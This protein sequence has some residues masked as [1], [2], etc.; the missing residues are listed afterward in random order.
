VSKFHPEQRQGL[1]DLSSKIKS[2]NETLKIE[3]SRL[4]NVNRKIGKLENLFSDTSSL[5]MSPYM[6]DK[7]NNAT[8]KKYEPFLIEL[9]SEIKEMR[10]IATKQIND[11][12]IVMSD[13][14]K[15]RYDFVMKYGEYADDLKVEK[16]KGF[17]KKEKLAKKREKINK[18][19]KIVKEYF[20]LFFTEYY[21]INNLIDELY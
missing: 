12:K 2:L 4:L 10:T 14:T 7:P 13:G 8:Y 15:M 21:S 20:D 16:N 1:V 6:D 18:Q 11:S 17:S 9:H 19:K 5:Q 3:E